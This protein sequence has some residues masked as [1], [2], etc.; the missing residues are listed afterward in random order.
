MIF[1]T[2]GTQLPFDRLTQAIDA[3][4][5]DRNR[6]DVFGQIAKPGTN[7]YHPTNFQWQYFVDP[8]EYSRLFAEA[9]FIVAHA[10][11]GSLITALTGAKP[12]VVMPRLASL[13][14]HRNDHQAVTADQ[15]SKR[16]GV[17]VAAN[18]AEILI[19]MDR[20][21]KIAATYRATH[22]AQYASPSLIQAIRSFIVDIVE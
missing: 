14:E 9:E 11:M 19:A 8:E 18:E 4:S 20:A 22:A 6:K 21:V 15:F 12:I 16:S 13:G 17:F 2:V 5:V 1:L 7:G 10:G 3:W